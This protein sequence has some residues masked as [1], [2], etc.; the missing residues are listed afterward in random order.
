MRVQE[1]IGDQA[2]HTGLRV[3][4]ESQ[5]IQGVDTWQLRHPEALTAFRAAMNGE[6]IPSYEELK[7]SLKKTEK[8]AGFESILEEHY[9][10]PK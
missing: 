7:P 9:L 5:G 10:K 4:L 8:G 1:W 6:E 3:W 2:Y